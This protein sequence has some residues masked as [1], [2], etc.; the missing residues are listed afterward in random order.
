MNLGLPSFRSLVAHIGEDL[1]FDPE[2]FLTLGDYQSLAEYYFLE[3]GSLGDLRS[4]LDTTWHPSTIDITKSRIHE[5]IVNLAFPIIY[6]TN[7]DRWLEEAHIKK[8][9]PFRKIVN[10]GDLTK[11]HSETEIVKFHGD[12]SKDE[13]IVLTESSYFGRFSFETPLDIK[14][15]SDSLGRP[16]LFIGYRLSDA[17]MRYLLYKLDNIWATSPQKNQ[18]PKSYILMNK[19]NVIQERI[20]EARGITPILWKH[21]DA[22]TALREFLEQLLR[23][24]AV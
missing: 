20:L 7:Y 4:W 11:P 14:L 1:G 24:C 16:L 10:V 13:S 22:G 15:R 12:F 19:P 21:D 2:I 9:K 18:R 8:G 5:L 3:R 17:N 6:T 23:E